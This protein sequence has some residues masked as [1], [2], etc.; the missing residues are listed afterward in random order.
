MR[1]TPPGARVGHAW[2][3]VRV[4]KGMPPYSG[5]VFSERGSMEEGRPRGGDEAVGGGL[6]GKGTAMGMLGFL[7]AE[8]GRRGRES[9]ADVSPKPRRTISFCMECGSRKMRVREGEGKGGRL[10]CTLIRLGGGAS[11]MM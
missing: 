9:T 3:K 5:A 6:G 2:E 1:F 7:V 8:V 10:T 11:A 4:M